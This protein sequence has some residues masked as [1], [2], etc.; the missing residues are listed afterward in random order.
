M[1]TNTSKRR[2]FLKKSTALASVSIIPAHVLWGKTAPS[3]QFRFAQIGCGGKGWVDRKGSIDAGGKLIALCDVDRERAKKATDLH[4]DLPFYED[5]RELLDKHENDLDG[6]VV[7]T[8]D[9]THA[10]VALNAI[11]RGKHAYIQKPLARTY[12]ECEALHQAATKHGVIT[13]MGNQG[14]AGDGLKVYRRLLEENAFG[15]VKEVHAWSNRPIWP[16][17]MQKAPPQTA[18]PSHLNWDLWLGPAANRDYAKEYLP[19]NWRGW[20]DFG[21][22]AMGDMACHNMDPLF[23]LFQLGLPKK[24]IAETA[25]KVDIAYPTSSK[26]HYTFDSAVTGKEMTLTWYDGKL[27]P[28]MPE[29]SHPELDAGTNGCMI[30]G[31]KATY[32]GGGT[33]DRPRPI[34]LTGKEYGSE[35]KE[36][37]RYWRKESKKYSKESPYQ[38]WIDASKAGKNNPLY[39]H[40]DYSVPFTQGILLGCIALRYPNQELIWDHQQKKFSNHSDANKWLSFNPRQGFSLQ[41]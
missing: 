40:I 3:N 17:G 35:V 30:K 14:H 31:S 1:T 10:C 27:R 6:V 18:I 36:L 23:T 5:Y 7:T 13:Q 21:C 32:M 8:P 16:Q 39:S 25:E 34:A 11:Q 9:H 24:I 4:S 12:Q 19:F 22:G 26:V 33:A 29:G 2:N 38:Q 28:D 15:D 41:A 37:E 20:W